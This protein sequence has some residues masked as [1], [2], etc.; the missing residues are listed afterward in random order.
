M[1]F[2]ENAENAKSYLNK[3]MNATIDTTDKRTVF[4]ASF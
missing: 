2:P 1:F 4:S 3:L